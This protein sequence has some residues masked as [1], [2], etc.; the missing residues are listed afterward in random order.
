MTASNS[1]APAPSVEPQ[2]KPSARVLVLPSRHW[3]AALGLGV[4]LLASG[5]TVLHRPKPSSAAPPASDPQPLRDNALSAGTPVF[6][7]AEPPP[8]AAIEPRERQSALGRQI[9][10][11]ASLSEPAGTSC[12]SCHDPKRAYS[13]NHGS[14]IG[15]ARGSLPGHFARR[16][17]P[18]LLYLKY[19]RKFHFHWEEDAPLP[20][21]VG[22]F[23][24]DGR[25]D[26]LAAVI[27]QRCSIQTRWAT[28]IPSNSC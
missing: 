11:D 9:F 7:V 16:N 15:V 22:G 21:A 26:S 28:P 17:T 14:K 6:T 10:F 19:V 1:A 12:A 5:A 3:R 18:S 23:F 24:W 27:R 2:A 4:L 25:A 13:G 20:D 8:R